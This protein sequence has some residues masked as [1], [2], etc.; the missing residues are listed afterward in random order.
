M[1]VEAAG[2]RSQRERPT[3]S[4]ARSASSRADPPGRRASRA[5]AARPTYGGGSGIGS[6]QPPRAPGSTPARS[7]PRAHRRPP[8]AARRRTGAGMAAPRSSWRRARRIDTISRRHG[9]P[10]AAILQANNMTPCGAAAAGPASG[11]SARAAADGAPQPLVPPPADARRGSGAMPPAPGNA[12]V[13]APGETIYSLARH[14]RLTPMAI[15][16]ANNVGLDHQ[17]RRSATGSSFRAA[18]RARACRLPPRSRR[19]A[20]A[21]AAASRAPPQARSHAR[22]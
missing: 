13:V 2:S 3:T 1:A 18:D 7:R 5:A 21:A 8:R 9:V 11:H 22:S 20:G 19:S 6:Y 16:K 10:A 15:A 4:P 12:H 14:Y 17:R